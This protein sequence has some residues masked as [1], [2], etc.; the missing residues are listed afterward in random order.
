M[1]KVYVKSVS[2]NAATVA[3]LSIPAEGAMFELTESQL[4]HFQH[5]KHF[6]L[7]E[8]APK[9]AE[10]KSE[11]VVKAIDAKPAEVKAAETKAK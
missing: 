5:D 4:I 7:L 2:G 10:V 1:S 3:G 9:P 6:E 11:V 8:K